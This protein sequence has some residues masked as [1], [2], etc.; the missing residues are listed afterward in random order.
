MKTR[1]IVGT[2]AALSAATVQAQSTITL[3]GVAE[4]G[5]EY[6]NKTAGNHSQVNMSAGNNPTTGSLWGLRG[7]EDL[8]GGLKSVFVLE[9]GFNPDN[10]T[11]ADSQRMF[12]NMAYMGVESALGAFTVG[13]QQT[14]MY[15]FTMAYDPMSG[16]SRYS[17]ATQDV[18]MASRADNAIKYTGRFGGL[19]MSALYSLGYDNASSVPG[20]GYGEIPGDYRSG[21]EYSGALHYETGPFAVGAV[22]DLRQP[23]ADTK[24][25]RASVAGHY[26]YGPG[27]IFAGYRWANLTGAGQADLRTNL[28]WLG[29]AYQATPAIT[30]KAAAYYQ[31]VAN[32]GGDPWL[33]VATA[34]YA[35]SKRTS[36]FFDIAYALNGTDDAG[37]RASSLM[38]GES[39]D[40]GANQFG[41]A[42]GIRH[43]F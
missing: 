16:T 18:G 5:V 22:Y 35:F 32:Q 17:M 10:G 4:V 33:F 9:S 3:Y 13:R 1:L 34:D 37:T 21:R 11:A 31:D 29:G 43:K 42:I 26:A 36:V 7:V 23:Y 30:L 24:L 15:D 39:I 12:N 40:P 25:Q 20:P 38:L 14:P 6:L 28:Y 41:A 19:T 27:R 2:L 8:G